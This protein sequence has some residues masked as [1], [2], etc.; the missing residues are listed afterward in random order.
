MR[1]GVLDVNQTGMTDLL[2]TISS[3]RAERFAERA[4][5]SGTDIVVAARSGTTDMP[6]NEQVTLRKSGEVVHAIR[7]G[8]PGAAVV[9]ASEF[10]R[11]VTQIKELTGAQ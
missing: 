7:G 3:L 11:I 6:V 1:E 4:L 5:A 10:D 9:P 8:E 2:N